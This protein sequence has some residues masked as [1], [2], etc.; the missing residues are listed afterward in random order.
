M[1]GIWRFV[2]RL[3]ARVQLFGGA[4]FVGTQFVPNTPGLEAITLLPHGY[5]TNPAADIALLDS[6]IA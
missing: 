3:I 5:R 6:N 1:D 4:L 2:S